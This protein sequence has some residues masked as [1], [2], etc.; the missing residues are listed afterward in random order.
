MNLNLNPLMELNFPSHTAL[1]CFGSK[2][3]HCG[4]TLKHA[5]IQSLDALFIFTFLI[6]FTEGC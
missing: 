6:I 3:T 5:S 4:F 2:M 1:V